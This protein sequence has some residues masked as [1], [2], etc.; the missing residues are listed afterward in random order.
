MLSDTIAN[1]NALLSDF[2]V[3]V[4]PDF[5]LDIIIDPKKPFKVLADQI[6][7]VYSRGGGNIIG[8]DIKFVAGG[9]GGNVAKTIAGLGA[10][11]AFITQT[12]DFGNKLLEFFL[13]PLNI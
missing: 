5:Y 8:T 7:S 3:S 6:N 12:S 10:K 2:S 1:L 13:E 11:T 4:L 9:N